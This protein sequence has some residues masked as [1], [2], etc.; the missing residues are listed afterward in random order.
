MKSKKYVRSKSDWLAGLKK[1]EVFELIRVVFW[2]GE[3]HV[4]VKD[5]KGQVHEYPDVFFV[6]CDKEGVVYEDNPFY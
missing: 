4:V 3:H 2:N 1:D 6:E 5:K